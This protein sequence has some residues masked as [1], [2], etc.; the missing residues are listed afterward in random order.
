MK[1]GDSLLLKL[2]KKYIPS[3]MVEIKFKG[4]DVCIRTDNE[5]NPVVVFIGKTMPNG[6][7]K[8]ERYTRTLIT[9]A[10]GA[11]IKDHWDLKGKATD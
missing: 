7:I 6:K 3:T 5:G 1:L 10:N 4:K 9:N 2:R 8:G 11:V